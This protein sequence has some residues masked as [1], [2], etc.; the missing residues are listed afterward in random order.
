[1]IARVRMDN[2]RGHGNL[3]RM[4]IVWKERD[5][6]RRQQRTRSSQRE[7]V[8]KSQVVWV[9]KAKEKRE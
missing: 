3:Y 6:L 5:I 4:Y 2:R 7:K 1:M 8:R 9:P